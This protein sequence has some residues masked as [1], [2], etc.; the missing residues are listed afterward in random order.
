MNRTRSKRQ[1]FNENLEQ[2]DLK[3]VIEP[4]LTIDE[5]KSK[6]GNDED[7][8][9]I[10][11][12]ARDEDPGMDLVS[13]IEKG[14]EWVMDAECAEGEELDGN[15][16]VFI[17]ADRTPRTIQNLIKMLDDLT[18]LTEITMDEWEF[19][20]YKDRSRKPLTLDNLRSAVPMTPEEYQKRYGEPDTSM[21]QVKTASG[22]NV[23]TK[24]PVN[25]FT[26]S[27]RIAAGLR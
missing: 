19:S 13:F 11:F 6:M 9:V 5:Y 25:D 1:Q 4:Y 18:N 23:D 7:V 10:K 14:Y 8:L 17:E 22:I 26:E 15:Y 27:I 3:K 21:D 16:Q 20:Y 2:G 12:E 24:A